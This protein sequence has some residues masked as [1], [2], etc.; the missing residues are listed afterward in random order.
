MI[1]IFKDIRGIV[2]FMSEKLDG[3]MKLFSPDFE[4]NRKRYLLKNN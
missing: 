2:V 1:E 4:L 3:D